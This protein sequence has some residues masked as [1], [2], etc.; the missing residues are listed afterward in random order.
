MLVSGHMPQKEGSQMVWALP[1]L[2][3]HSATDPSL[4]S[5]SPG[6]TSRIKGA[7]GPYHHQCQKANLD[8]ALLSKFGI[9]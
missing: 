3:G 7:P 5:H 8:E 6:K 9:I 4:C 2:A 1:P